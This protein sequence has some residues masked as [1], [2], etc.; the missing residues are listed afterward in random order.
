MGLNVINLNNLKKVYLLTGIINAWS[1]IG[2]ILKKELISETM[3][4]D[5]DIDALLE[6]PYIKSEVYIR[7]SIWMVRRSTDLYISTVPSF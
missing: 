1:N 4:D 6:A 5:L 2:L 3:A 7:P